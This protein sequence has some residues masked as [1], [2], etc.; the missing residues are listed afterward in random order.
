MMSKPLWEK[1]EQPAVDAEVFAFTVGDDPVIDNN[2]IPYDVIGSIAHVEGLERIAVLSRE[3]SDALKSSLQSIYREWEAGRFR[4][5]AE[6]EDVHS[7]LERVL[8]EQLGETGRKVHAGRS[9]ND[10]VLTALRLYMKAAVADMTSVLAGLTGTCIEAGK[11][12]EQALMPGY[13]HGR[14]AMPSSVGFWFASFADDWCSQLEQGRALFRQLDASPL[15]AAAG[16]GVPLQLDRQFV[17][18]RM[19]FSRVQV[20]AAAVQNSRGRDA[21]AVLS[22]LVEIG[23]G[24]EKMACDLLQ[25]ATREFGFVSVPEDF[26][27]GSSIMPHKKN[28]DVFEL[29]RAGPS[30]VRACRD[31]VERVIEKL[32]SNYHRDFQLS[33]APLFRGV[34]RTRTM[35]RILN[36]SLPRL[37]WDLERM[38][39]ACTDEIY[40]THRAVSLVGAGLPF[41]DAYRQAA[42]ELST[43]DTEDWEKD[44]E[45][46]LATLTHLGAP[47]N[48]GLNEAA[49]RLS[50]ARAWAEDQSARLFAAWK[51]L[52]T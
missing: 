19:G 36:R 7:A 15:G 3:E 26:C 31:E 4:V 35:L 30:L 5:G 49:E 48:P 12:H 50:A 34:E 45:T 43:G 14:R 6:D 20:N 42:E 22:W 52:L 8:T 51:A 17:A 18:E 32:P 47:G 41:R 33:K 21:C 40:A 16:F 46:V 38:R 24:V 29:L 1:P 10:Q 11:K 13:T 27:T 39:E 44:P 23:R 25:F 2:L 28:P 9:R 37:T